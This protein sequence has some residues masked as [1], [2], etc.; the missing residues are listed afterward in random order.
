MCVVAHTPHL[1]PLSL[2]ITSFPCLLFQYTGQ[3]NKHKFVV[4]SQDTDLRRRLRQVPGVP[5]VYLNRTTLILEPP[6]TKSA[7]VK[8]KVSLARTCV[9]DLA[10]MVRPL[11]DNTAHPTP[12]HPRSTT[13]KAELATFASSPRP[14]VCSGHAVHCQLRNQIIKIIEIMDLPLRIGRA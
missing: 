1:P 11:T 7:F 6:S 10:E 8:A 12:P 5:L 3:T 4:A 9:F 14:Y 13:E 2:I